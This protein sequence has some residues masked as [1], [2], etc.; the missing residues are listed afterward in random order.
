MRRLLL[1]LLVVGLV[2]IAPVGSLAGGGGTLTVSPASVPL[3][4]TFTLSGDGYPTPTSISFEVSGPRKA[5]PPIH[6]FTAGEPLDEAS[7]GHFSES[8]VAWWGVA[9]EYQIT[10]YFRDSKG[11]SHKAGVVKFTVTP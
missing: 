9:G 10:S 6:Y 4:S 7:G 11:G 3:G 5:D 1:A 2:A 8:W